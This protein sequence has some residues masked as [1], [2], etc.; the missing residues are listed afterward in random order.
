MICGHLF[1]AA[2]DCATYRPVGYQSACQ[3]LGMI[4][5]LV[6]RDSI[7]ERC[8]IRIVAVGQDAGSLVLESSREKVGW[9]EDIGLRSGP[10]IVGM[11]VQ[12]MN[13]DNVNER[14]GCRV[15]FCKAIL[16]DWFS[17]G[18]TH[19]ASLLGLCKVGAF[20]ESRP[21]CRKEEGGKKRRLQVPNSQQPTTNSLIREDADARS[22]V[23]LSPNF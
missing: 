5:Y 1:H 22:D 18:G 17:G 14:I 9:P 10:G 16:L 11:A 13:E 23:A 21:G 2:S 3:M 7:C 20:M 19:P 4:V 8:N 12:T 6:F 15:D